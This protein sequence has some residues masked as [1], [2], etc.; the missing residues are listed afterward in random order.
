MSSW[1]IAGT[2]SPSTTA[3]VDVDGDVTLDPPP[4][5]SLPDV[6]DP[7]T[8]VTIRWRRIDRRRRT[9][10]VD[11]IVLEA[12]LSALEATLEQK[13]RQLNAVIDRYERLLAERDRELRNRDDHGA[14]TASHHSL[15]EQ[16]GAAVSSLLE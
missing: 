11:R 10:A 12:R 14:E 15:G 9:T 16:L 1:S 2:H 7:A 5:T 8:D 13:D 6:T 3:G 4:T